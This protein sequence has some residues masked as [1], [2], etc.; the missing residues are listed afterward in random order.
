MADPKATVR[1]SDD[2][3][4]VGRE[5]KPVLVQAGKALEVVERGSM[6]GEPLLT[7]RLPDGSFGTVLPCET[8]EFCHAR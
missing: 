6:F 8:E 1:L 7:V 5:G 4:F 3:T 2:N